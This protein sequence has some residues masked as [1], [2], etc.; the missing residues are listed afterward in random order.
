MPDEMESV[1]G[2]GSI[3]YKAAQCNVVYYNPNLTYALP[4]NADGSLFA[5]P[6]FTSAFYDGYSA[7]NGGSTATVDLSASFQA[8]DN[9]TLRT[10]G[11]NDTPQPG[12][13]YYYTGNAGTAP[14]TAY[15]SAPCGDNDV[16]MTV[17][18]NDGAAP[19]GLTWA[20]T[21]TRV[22]VGPNSGIGNTDERLNFAIWYRSE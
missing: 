21:W 12:Y 16:N 7:F 13:Y 11:Y 17:A 20:G 6:S 10:S 2:I 4:K 18:S 5:V 22:V 3:G 19:G 14:I 15:N 1:I 8:Y 9:N